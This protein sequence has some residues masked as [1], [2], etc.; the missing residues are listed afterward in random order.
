MSLGPSTFPV[1][2]T[3]LGTLPW[4]FVG[5]FLEAQNF[6]NYYESK[7]VF[8]TEEKPTTENPKIRV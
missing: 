8:F 2:G 1:P 7:Y 4:T 3:F 5:T 6:V